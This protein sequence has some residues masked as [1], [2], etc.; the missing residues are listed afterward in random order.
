MKHK[1]KDVPAPISDL[2]VVGTSFAVSVSD[3]LMNFLVSVLTGSTVV[4]SQS[5]QGLSDLATAGILLVG[6]RRS[7]R[8]PDETYHFGYGR[9]VFFY[10]LLAGIF[11]FMG[12]GALSVY[13]GVQQIIN[14]EALEHTWVAIAMLTFGFISNAY[15]F[16][17]SARRL[18]VSWQ[19]RKQLVRAI[20]SSMVETKATFVID[21]LGTLAALFGLVALTIY[22]VTGNE[23]F[24]G[25]GSVVV[26]LLMMTGA[27]LLMIDAKELIV[28]RSVSKD[29]LSAMRTTL[30]EHEMVQAVL[31]LR[32]MYLGS[33]SLLV[34]AEV[35]FRDGLETDEIERISD[36]L[37]DMIKDN[38]N[39]VDRVQIEAETPER[40]LQQ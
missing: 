14:P 13:F 16:R 29:A 7:R 20:R 25:A 21:F 5:L 30:L 11:M 35:H 36:E 26:G 28:G 2:R 22:I 6:V 27:S 34:I 38:H 17:L 10:V 32:T 15:A 18:R 33:G 12:T 9:E 4:L 8:K 24:D 37:K 19:S 3:V 39:I 31:D 1:R 40:E 23:F